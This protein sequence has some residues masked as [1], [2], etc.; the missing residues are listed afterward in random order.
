MTL[1]RQSRV[2]P[3]GAILAHH[4]LPALQLLNQYTLW[5]HVVELNGQV[6]TVPVTVA[7]VGVILLVAFL[8]CESGGAASRSATVTPTVA[9]VSVAVK[10][11]ASSTA[12][13]TVPSASR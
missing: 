1:A 10:S 4:V 12:A 13:E 3:I 5:T 6:N 11:S 2:A 8:A 7:D 9:M